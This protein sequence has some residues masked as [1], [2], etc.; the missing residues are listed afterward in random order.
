MA[1]IVYID[2]DHPNTREVSLASHAGIHITGARRAISRILPV[3]G[4]FESV[5]LLS[6]HPANNQKTGLI[7]E[8]RSERLDEM[9]LSPETICSITL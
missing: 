5:A 1:A 3:V 6:A 8:L 7:S 9:A 4:Y 2:M